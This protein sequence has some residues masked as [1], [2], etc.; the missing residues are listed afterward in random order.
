MSRQLEERGRPPSLLVLLDGVAP[1]FRRRSLRAGARDIASGVKRRLSREGLSGRI[2]RSQLASRHA[3]PR[4]RPRPTGVPTA[5]LTSEARRTR[6][7]DPLLGWGRFLT[8]P[9]VPKEFPGRHGDLIRLRTP[10][11][12]TELERLLGEHDPVTTHA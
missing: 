9:V 12:A 1:S 5:L 3:A 4:H 2:Q 8:G 11:T 7:G 6:V 10:G